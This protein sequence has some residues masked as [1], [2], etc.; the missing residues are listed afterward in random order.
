MAEYKQEIYKY[1]KQDP[2]QGDAALGTNV[3]NKTRRFNLGSAA[4]KD[5]GT[6]EEQIPQNKDLHEVSQTGNYEDLENKPDLHPVAT[7]GDFQDLS[8][9]PADLD[10]HPIATSGDYDDLENK[11]DL[12]PVATSGDYEDLTNRPDEFPALREDATITVG[13]EGDYTT[14]NDAL[15][16][17]SERGVVYRKNGINVTIRLLADFVMEEQVL[18]NDVDLG[19]ITIESEAGEDP[20]LIERFEQGEAIPGYDQETIFDLQILDFGYTDTSLLHSQYL[21]VQDEFDNYH[22]FWFNNGGGSDP[23]PTIDIGEED[24]LTLTSGFEVSI[25]NYEKA[26]SV[27]NK[28]KPLIDNLSGLST[29]KE[30]DFTLKFLEGSIVQTNGD[31]L[32]YQI[33]SEEYY[34]SINDYL[35]GNEPINNHSLNAFSPQDDELYLW[36]NVDGQGDAPTLDP[37]VDEIEISIDVDEEFESVIQKISDAI[38]GKEYFE[39]FLSERTITIT[40]TKTGETNEPVSSGEFFNISVQQFGR[41]EG[42][43]TKAIVSEHSFEEGQRILIRN[44]IGFEEEVDYNGMW[45]I[46]N[47]TANAFELDYDMDEGALYDP[48]KLGEENTA[49]AVFPRPVPVK[50]EALTQQWEFFYYPAFG[51]ARGTLPTINTIFEMDDS[52]PDPSY[53]SYKDGFCATDQGRIN[54]MPFAGFTNAEGTNIYGTRG[55]I[56]NANDAIADYAGRYG[57][58]AYANT[59]INARRAI[60]SNCGWVAQIQSVVINEI[61][62]GFDFFDDDGFDSTGQ[63][64]GSGIIATRASMINADGCVAENNVGCNIVS[65]YGATINLGSHTQQELRVGGSVYGE[66]IRCA[67]GFVFI[68][69]GLLEPSIIRNINKIG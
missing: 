48:L 60:A 42:H 54:I 5:V 40:A 32:S 31:D 27:L 26:D 45:F 36:L 10:F 12:Q 67:T 33:I 39:T 35:V 21:I 43:Y 63:S 2:E 3:N 8:N 68:N 28:L 61:P 6:S 37:E 49:E 25:S 22:Y 15:E 69:G 38:D 9:K 11:P 41:D 7:S 4:S 1:D 44:H 23:Q 29:E 62:G 52:G 14:I 13:P 46:T 19:W 50:K 55:S 56:I 17:L 24:P 59:Q 58:W 65:E 30:D 57:I 16:A 34:F 18:V 64:V 20:T 66:D 53:M 47:V 51:A